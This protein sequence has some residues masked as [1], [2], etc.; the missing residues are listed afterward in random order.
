M[1]WIKLHKSIMDSAVWSDEWIVKLWLW[2]LLKANSRPGD[3]RGTSVARGQFVTGRNTA[4]DEL[5]V[6]P[7]KWMRGIMRLV[8]LGCIQYEANSQWTRLTV[9]NYS[10]YQD[11]IDEDRT[12]NGQRTDSEWTADDTAS[13]QPAIQ[14]ADTILEVKSV[15]SG[16]SNSTHTHSRGDWSHL[17]ESVQKA[18][19]FWNRYWIQTHG[20]GKEDSDTRIDAMLI[21]A[22]SAGWSD[23]KIA[24]SITVSIGWN[25]K[26]WR[27]PDA[28]HDKATKARINGRKPKHDPTELPY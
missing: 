16:E 28:D 5:G 18:I 9:C 11:R 10:A 17:S 4:S 15:R 21:T 14:R 2:C 3:F 20:N 7:S 8:K 26:S 25:A 24:E 23:E 19:G 6:S 22:K 13:G 12:A 1:P 27:D